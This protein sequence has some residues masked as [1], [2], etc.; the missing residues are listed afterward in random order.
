[1][2]RRS[3]GIFCG[4][5]LTQSLGRLGALCGGHAQRARLNRAAAVMRRRGSV[6][7]LNI[8]MQLRKAC[9]HPYLFEG[10]EDRTLN[11]MGEHLVEVRCALRAG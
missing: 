5:T 7:L 8:V 9:A 11:P 10:V 4:G 6:R 3:T 1:M 2:C